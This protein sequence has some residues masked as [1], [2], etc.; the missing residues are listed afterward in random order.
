MEQVTYGTDIK[1]EVVDKTL[2]YDKLN[3]EKGYGQITGTGETTLTG[4]N[5]TSEDRI[6]IDN[7]IFLEGESQ[8]RSLLGYNVLYYARI[9]KT[10]D[11]KTLIDV[12]PQSNKNKSVAVPAR[13]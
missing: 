10:T 13:R 3:V 9:D 11:E 6:Q 7:K 4:G 8:A 12:R 2:L 1:Y 5:T